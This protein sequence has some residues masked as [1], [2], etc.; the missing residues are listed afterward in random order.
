MNIVLLSCYEQGQQSFN[1]ASPLA[2]FRQAGFNVAA[3]D[4]AIQQFPESS[5]ANSS[6][7]AVSTPM[8]TALKLA[9]SL[10]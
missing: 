8:H 2:A 10:S 1:L 5:V 3:F 4:L 9:V 7:V 6:L